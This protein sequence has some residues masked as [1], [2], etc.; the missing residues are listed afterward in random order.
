MDEYAKIYYVRA[1][2]ETVDF[3]D[4]SSRV[5]LR[6]DLKCLSFKWYL[7]NI[8]PELTIP[9]NIAEGYVKNDGL[10]NKTCLDITKAHQI[11][12][13]HCHNQGGP[14]FIEYSLKKELRK[15]EFCFDFYEKLNL[16]RCHGKKGNQEWNFN[17]ITKQFVHEISQKCLSADVVNN[18]VIVETCDDQRA[19][20]KWSF[21]FLY[22][23]KM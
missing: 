11:G 4:V 13:Y 15:G 23:E 14:Q 1:G 8:Y 17:V 7:E 19:S 3:G 12:F 10:S 20:Q 2:A 21:Q 9:N 16:N 18:A 5:K 22:K 6:Q